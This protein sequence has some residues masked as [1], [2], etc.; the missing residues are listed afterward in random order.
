MSCLK[1]SVFYNYAYFQKREP[2]LF[3]QNQLLWVNDRQRQW[4]YIS[5][6]EYNPS[7]E[8]FLLITLVSEDTRLASFYRHGDRRAQSQPFSFQYRALLSVCPQMPWSDIFLSGG[9]KRL[10]PFLYS[11]VKRK[12]SNEFPP[13]NGIYLCLLLW[14]FS[15]CAISF[16]SFK[17]KSFTL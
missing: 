7:F 1:L 14:R 12:V 8:S 16:W 2:V 10:S 11:A 15:K 13:L 6:Q 4:W 9:N 3:S 17:L 5:H